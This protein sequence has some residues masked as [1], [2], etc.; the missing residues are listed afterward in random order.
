MPVERGWW[1]R[2]SVQFRFVIA[3]TMLIVL[4]ASGGLA[5][6]PVI[7]T[8]VRGGQGLTGE[9]LRLGAAVYGL[10]P[11]S[12]AIS[13]G[14]SLDGD[15]EAFT[16][17]YR[18]GRADG[19]EAVPSIAV[20]CVDVGAAAHALVARDVGSFRIEAG[21]GLAWL[22]TTAGLERRV[23]ER[24]RPSA[25]ARASY[26]FSLGSGLLGHWFLGFGIEER[27]VDSAGPRS[28]GFLSFE[29]IALRPE[30]S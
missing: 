19:S 17:G 13:L 18:C 21:A 1:Y 27:W 25:L 22:A 9:R 30:P 10:F 7:G 8:S 28:A 12:D 14:A 20:T 29:A 3:L 6:E 11:I 5:A 4:L 23:G 2:S 15:G 26:R 16:G 24:W